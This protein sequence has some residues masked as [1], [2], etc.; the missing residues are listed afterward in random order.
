MLEFSSCAALKINTI[1][2]VFR[3]EL[4]LGS[5]VYC[6]TQSDSCM[7]FVSTRYERALENVTFP[8]KN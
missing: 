6:D 2:H 3:T 4:N 8:A 7:A 1:D 5:L